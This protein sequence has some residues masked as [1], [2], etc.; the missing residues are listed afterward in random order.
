MLP[1]LD[2]CG[3]HPSPISCCMHEQSQTRL[4]LC[5]CAPYH[6]HRC[7]GPTTTTQMPPS[8]WALRSQ[9][10][11]CV[12]QWPARQPTVMPPLLAAALLLRCAVSPFLQQCQVLGRSTAEVQS[13]EQLLQGRILCLGL[14]LLVLLLGQQAAKEAPGTWCCP[15]IRPSKM[16]CSLG[17]CPATGRHSRYVFLGENCRTKQLCRGASLCGKTACFAARHSGGLH[18]LLALQVNQQQQQLRSALAIT[19]PH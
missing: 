5:V 1:L 12:Q 17:A 19:A 4:S 10:Q 2:D 13:Q 6:C 7:S 18:V 8:C 3:C 11:R 9:A 15:W 16:K 14:P